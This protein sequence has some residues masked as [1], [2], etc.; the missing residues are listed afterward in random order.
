MPN[1]ELHHAIIDLC[2]F[3]PLRLPVRLISELEG[4]TAVRNDRFCL[5]LSH[6]WTL[7]SV[8]SV[9]SSRSWHSKQAALYQLAAD[10][11]KRERLT[12]DSP[13]AIRGLELE[14]FRACCLTNVATLEMAER[15]L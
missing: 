4:Q 2:M 5:I 10:A 13:E 8:C 11:R 6:V 14:V 1:F 7:D 3:L 12:E 9:A 15:S